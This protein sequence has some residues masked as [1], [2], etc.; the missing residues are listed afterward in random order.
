MKS[1]VKTV[2]L[3]IF[4]N[5]FVGVSDQIEFFVMA[6]REYGYDVTFGRHPRKTALNVIIENFD[7]HSYKI[8]K[9]FCETENKKIAVIMTEHLDLINGKILIHG[10]PLWSVNDYMA[11]ETQISR[12]RFLFDLF[13]YLKSLFTLGDLP[14]LENMSQMLP[15]IDIRRIPFPKL[16][17]LETDDS[18]TDLEGELLF[19]GIATEFRQT[20]L[21]TLKE[22]NFV[23]YYPEKMVS[24]SVRNAMNRKAKI[25]MNL[26]QRGNWQWLSLMRIFAGLYCG[27]ASV[28]IAT[29]DNSE[30]SSCCYQ[31]N[32]N[33]PDWLDQLRHYIDNYKL[34]YEEA[35]SN[36]MA[37]A[38]RFQQESPFPHDLFE[39]WSITDNLS[40]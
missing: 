12:I 39:I 33:N 29:N 34:Y 22:N 24:R 35:H 9:D 13:P 16:N 31:L 4:N 37:M 1:K 23:T 2:H 20:I 38:E 10:S 11:P 6:L 19:T 27:R 17:F 21:N 30:I 7:S 18:D 14:K 5:P 3:W 15:E 25:I 26:P 8:V 36:Y 40:S 32:I 28:S